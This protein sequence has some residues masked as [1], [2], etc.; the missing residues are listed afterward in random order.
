MQTQ[1]QGDS[2]FKM[3]ERFLADDDSAGGRK[4]KKGLEKE[5]ASESGA[6]KA[7]NQER[8]KQLEILSKVTGKNIQEQ[9]QYRK[10]DPGSKAMQRFDPSTQDKAKKEKKQTEEDIIEAKKAVR[11]EDNFQVSEDKFYNVSDNLTQ[12]L[13]GGA[14]GGFSLLAMFGKAAPANSDNDEENKTV[15]E[16]E[17]P[18]FKDARFRYESSASEDEEDQQEQQVEDVA[19]EQTVPQEGDSKKKKKKAGY[20]S[21]QGIWKENLFFLPNDARLEEGR[22]FFLEFANSA[23]E[24]NTEKNTQA[25]DIRKIFKKRRMR[26]TKNVNQMRAKRGLKLMKRK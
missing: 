8:K 14:T 7:N 1:F 18:A 11:P 13:G 16:S 20:F 17:K 9:S 22:K 2:R 4:R 6:N 26:E 23:A 10:E 19:K 24:A 15:I 12:A 25:K 5:R 3:D 21:K